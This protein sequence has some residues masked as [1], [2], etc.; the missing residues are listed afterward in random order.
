MTSKE[1]KLAVVN[2]KSMTAMELK[3]LKEKKRDNSP[4]IQ[5][6]VVDLEKNVIQKRGKT[7]VRNMDKSMNN[8]FISSRTPRTIEI[9]LNLFCIFFF[10]ETKKKIV[11][12]NLKLLGIREVGSNF[13]KQMLSPSNFFQNRNNNAMRYSS[14]DLMVIFKKK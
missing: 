6:S 7:I 5:I 2:S 9:K 4:K 1:K 13:S 11:N 3:K 14:T 8:S 12:R 10:F